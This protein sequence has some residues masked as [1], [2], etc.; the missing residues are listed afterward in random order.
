MVA[1]LYEDNHLLILNKPA[2]ILTQPSGTEYA[3][4]EDQA[5]SYLKMTYQKPGNVYLH[6]VHR[7]DRAVSGIVVFAKTSKALS[8]LNE[9]MRKHESK[10]FYQAVVAGVLAGPR[11]LEHF[12]V[13][14]DHI[15]QVASPKD[16]KAK[17][18][19][20]HYKVLKQGK[21]N[22]LIEIEL[23]TG[24]YHQI[25]AQMAASGHSIMGDVKYG[26][27]QALPEGAIALQHH[28]FEMVHPVTHQSLKIQAPDLEFFHQIL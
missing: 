19:R 6:A 4:L 2:G 5:K 25:R 9:M 3:N 24:R 28:H 22:S 21:S 12:L 14:D 17:L 10:K 27:R 1:I 26:N 11:T 8:R 23:E 7:L 20:L 15:A 18:C 16:P 13:H